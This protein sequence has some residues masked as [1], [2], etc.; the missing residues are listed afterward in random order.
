[1]ADLA[2][3]DLAGDE[4]TQTGVPIIL[5]DRCNKRHPIMRGHCDQCVAPAL[6][7]KD[8]LCLRC[9]GLRADVYDLNPTRFHAAPIGPYEVRCTCG[10]VSDEKFTDL[11]AADADREAHFA[12]HRGEVGRG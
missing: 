10:Y 2:L 11:A 12:P 1:M 9:R 6:F 7:L 3:F 8:G 5:C 4:T